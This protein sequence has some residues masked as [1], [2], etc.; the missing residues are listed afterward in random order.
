MYLEG[1][2]RVDTRSAILDPS[3]RNWKPN[4]ALVNATWTYWPGAGWIDV[5]SQRAR[6][7]EILQARH[8]YTQEDAYKEID[9]FVNSLNR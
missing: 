9:T 7:V 8:G 5:S 3:K 2:A 4:S 1:L 6:L